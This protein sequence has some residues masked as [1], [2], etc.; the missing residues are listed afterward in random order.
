MLHRNLPYPTTF[1][2]SGLPHRSLSYSI[3]FSLSG[4]TS[5]KPLLLPSLPLSFPR[6]LFLSSQTSLSHFSPGLPSDPSL[7]AFPK[8]TPPLTLPSSS[9]LSSFP[10][11][12]SSFYFLLPLPHYIKLTD[13]LSAV[14]SSSSY[15][16][17]SGL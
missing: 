6:P 14:H 12:T 9:S 11:K 15:K 5:Q 1:S 4:L 13:H 10:A 7:P 2:P 17:Q 3:S 8:E 16:L